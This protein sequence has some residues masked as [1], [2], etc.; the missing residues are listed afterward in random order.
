MKVLANFVLLLNAHG[1]TADLLLP[2]MSPNWLGIELA[3]AD[4]AFLPGR[5]RS[6]GLPGAAD[7][8]ELRS[9]LENRKIKAA[10]V[11]GEDPMRDN[12]TA[13][14]FADIEFLAAMDWT[15]TETTQFANVAIPS[16]TWLESEGTRCN[17]EGNLINYNQA[18]TPPSGIP[19][20]KVLSE[21]LS[22]AGLKTDHKKASDITTQIYKSVKSSS[23]AML[24]AYWNTGQKR[25]WDKSGKLVI[26]D[27]STKP[28]RLRP[29][30]SEIEHY[31]REIRELG[32][33]R[34]RVHRHSLD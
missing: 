28:R 34:F 19:G 12:R 23:G 33:D 31:K 14:Y 15:V 1:I 16:T 10:L 20:W 18:L 11:I 17:Y 13:A 5:V 25:N 24:P 32:I 9:L 4:P 30:M 6:T 3:G 7:H 29:A 22:A 27:V 8:A 21:L 26:V 2:T